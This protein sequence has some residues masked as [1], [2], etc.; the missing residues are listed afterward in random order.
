MFHNFI[1]SPEVVMFVSD[2]YF[3]SLTSRCT[4]WILDNLTCKLMLTGRWSVS[5][6]LEVTGGAAVCDVSEENVLKEPEIKWWSDIRT[7]RGRVGSDSY[8]ITSDTSACLTAA[9]HHSPHFTCFLLI[10][11]SVMNT[12]K[13]PHRY[14]SGSDLEVQTHTRSQVKV[15]KTTFISSRSHF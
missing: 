13:T 3:E 6:K 11:A 10:K 5:V 7:S 2:L 8:W 15:K 9:V 14:C 1:N 4:L 12:V